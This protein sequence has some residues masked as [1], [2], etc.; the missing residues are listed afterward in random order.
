MTASAVITA[1]EAVAHDQVGRHR[2]GGRLRP[3]RGA[4]DADRRARRPLRRDRPDDRLE[5]HRRARPRARQA[6]AAGA[7]QARD[8]VLL[9]LEPRGRRGGQRRRDRGDPRPPG[10]VRRG[11]PGRWRRHRRLL[12]PGRRGHTARR[13]Q[14]GAPDRRRPARARGADP[15]RRGARLRGP[16][17]R[18]RQPLVPAHGPELQPVDGDCGDDH[19][20]GGGR[21]RAGRRARARVGRDPAPLRRLP[22]GENGHE[23]RRQGPD[24]RAG[25]AGAPTRR[26]R[27]PRDRHPEPDPWVPR[28][29]LAGRP[30]H[31]ERPA[32]RRPAPGRGRA[33]PRPDRRGQAADHRA[34]RG[35]VLRQ[36]RRASR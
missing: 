28:R 1:E 35:V 6:A 29:R 2:H 13:G 24:R 15:G 30:A 31:G 14:G 33:R 36:R 5:Q 7:D 17:R 21:D 32:R 23:R 3:G 9:H 4:A 22:G 12:H 10:H 26:D 8:L 27:Q 18:A 19:D 20:R 34:A 16:R 25:G 11:D